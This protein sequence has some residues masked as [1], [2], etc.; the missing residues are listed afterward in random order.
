MISCNTSESSSLSN[1]LGDNSQAKDLS[2]GTLHE[3]PHGMLM[4]TRVKELAVKAPRVNTTK[5]SLP[6]EP[7]QLM[8]GTT[9]HGEAREGL[10][11]ELSKTNPPY[12]PLHGSSRP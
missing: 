12:K 4:A 6:R 5:A 11:S 1:R 2:W 10:G 8:E 7:K 9:C 3:G